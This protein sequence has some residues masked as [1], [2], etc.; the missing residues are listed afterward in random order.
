MIREQSMW[1]QMQGLCLYPFSLEKQTALQSVLEPLMHTAGS[2][3]IVHIERVPF[4]FL[5]CF[6]SSL[7]SFPVSFRS[8]VVC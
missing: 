3:G 8:I 2:V 4:L 7:S 1:G 6:I 5:S